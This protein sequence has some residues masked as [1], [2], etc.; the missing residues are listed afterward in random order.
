MNKFSRSFSITASWK[1]IF[2]TLNFSISAVF[3]V[4]VVVCYFH[5]SFLFYFTFV[6][7]TQAM[8]ESFWQLSHFILCKPII[9]LLDGVTLSVHFWTQ[10]MDMLRVHLI[11]VSSIHVIA[12]K[13][14]QIRLIKL[15]QHSTVPNLEHVNNLCAK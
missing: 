13:W 3:D 1:L 2:T 6:F 12:P 15:M 10:S 8:L 4:I 11:K 7:L 5:S 14:P 9:L